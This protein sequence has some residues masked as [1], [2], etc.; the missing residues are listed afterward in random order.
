MLFC[1]LEAFERPIKAISQSGVVEPDEIGAGSKFEH[2]IRSKSLPNFITL[3]AYDK[4]PG[5][6]QS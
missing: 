2:L 4:P 1:G 6:R 3:G 5:T